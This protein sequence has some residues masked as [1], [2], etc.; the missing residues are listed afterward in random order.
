MKTVHKLLGA[1]LYDSR[2]KR[3]K[4][5]ATDRRPTVDVTATSSDNFTDADLVKPPQTIDEI[6]R[7]QNRRSQDAQPV[8]KPY[9]GKQ[10]TGVVQDK[11][12]HE[13]NKL[14]QDCISATEINL[15]ASCDIVTSDSSIDS[16]TA[17]TDVQPVK[18]HSD[19]HGSKVKTGTIPTNETALSVD[20][21]NC[22][23]KEKVVQY[24][25]AVG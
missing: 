23:P 22:L 9:V 7:L 17:D 25:H 11:A 1:R 18:Y 14:A 2:A 24:L 8:L 19:S 15:A 10:K 6:R 20:T 12:V 21:N 5:K 16:N 4:L 3:P 13:A